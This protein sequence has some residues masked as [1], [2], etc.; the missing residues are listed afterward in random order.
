MHAVILAAGY[1]KKMRSW[2]DL[3]NKCFLKIG[4]DSLLKYNIRMMLKLVQISKI[5]IVVGEGANSIKEDI[6]N[7]VDGVPV[8]YLVQEKLDGILGALYTVS[9]LDSDI[10]VQLGDEYYDSPRYEEGLHKLK[11]NDCVIGVVDGTQEQIKN[12]YSINLSETGKPDIFC[13]KPKEAFNNLVGTGMFFMKKEFLYVIRKLYLE[14]KKR[15]LVDLFNELT[16]IGADIDIFNA[17]RF[18]VNLNEIN[19]YNKVLKHR[20]NKDL[21]KYFFG[22]LKEIYEMHRKD[23]EVVEFYNSKFAEVYDKLCFTGCTCEENSV[24]DELDED[25]RYKD[26]IEFYRSYL[27]LSGGNKV[28]ELACGSGRV[29]IPFA[30]M[31]VHITGVDLSQDMLSILKKNI[32][33]KNRKCKKYITLV[34]DDITKLEKVEEKFNLIIF[35]ATTIRLLDVDLGKFI[36]SIY[37]FLEDGGYFIFDFIENKKSKESTIVE[38]SYNAS[39]V[40][41]GVKTVVFLQEEHDFIK[42]KSRINFYVNSFGKEIEHYLSYTYLNIVDRDILTEDIHNTRFTECSFQTYMETADSTFIFC[43]LKK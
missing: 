12:N 9:N 32:E 27:A 37:D 3:D 31:K 23:V 19:D 34:Q 36:D 11:D 20:E 38:N 26:E 16:K 6:G 18:Y 25:E 35:A 42:Q 4:K 13:E 33:E 7:D 28:L 39:Y 15:E 40:N 10:L 30:K 14:D 1:G 17:A 8:V 21:S 5:V 22:S 29:T 24:L 2:V 41:E 43:V